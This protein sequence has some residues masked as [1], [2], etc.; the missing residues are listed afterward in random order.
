MTYHHP[1]CHHPGSS[2][3]CLLPDDFIRFWTRLFAAL[4]TAPAPADSEQSQRDPVRTCIRPGLL[5]RGPSG[6]LPPPSTAPPAWTAFPDTHPTCS[7]HSSSSPLECH[8]PWDSRP[9]QALEV[10]HP[11]HLTFVL[12][13]VALLL[14][15]TLNGPSFSI[16]TLLLLPPP[17]EDIECRLLWGRLFSCYSRST[18]WEPKTCVR[19]CVPRILPPLLPSES[20]SAETLHETDVLALSWHVLR[21][22]SLLRHI[23]ICCFLHLEF[24]YPNPTHLWSGQDWSKVFFQRG[25]LVSSSHFE[26]F[27]EYSRVNLTFGKIMYTWHLGYWNGHLLLLLL[28][29]PG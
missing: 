1:F 9:S 22:Q 26:A 28:F 5:R 20:G 12:L 15:T 27:S 2:D 10:H 25:L 16:C 14:P 19:E 11:S 24:S 8:L 17:H 29:L 13:Y 23:L 7:L 4:H 6:F 21:F 18:N 3:Y